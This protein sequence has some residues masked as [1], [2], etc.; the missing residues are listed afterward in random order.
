MRP[1]A[2]LVKRTPAVGQMLP[3]TY[4]DVPRGVR[5]EESVI[6]NFW[7]KEDEVVAML[8]KTFRYEQSRAL[9]S[10]ALEL[11]NN[12]RLNVRWHRLVS[13]KLHGILCAA[14]GHG[15]QCRDVLKHLTAKTHTSSIV[16]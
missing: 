14:L 8:Q 7:M 12:L 11:L 16:T 3:P 13:V 10:N 9:C 4:W 6:L 1:R 5:F 15:S 2:R